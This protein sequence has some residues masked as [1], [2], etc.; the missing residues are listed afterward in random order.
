M[1]STSPSRIL[2]THTYAANKHYPREGEV[3]VVCLSQPLFGPGSTLGCGRDLPS[4]ATRHNYH[5]AVVLGLIVDVDQSIMEL[6][7]FPAPAYSAIDPISGLS[8]TRWLLSQP[9]DYQNT[10]IPLPYEQIPP[11]VQPNP[12]FPIPAQFGD[13]IEVG[14]WKD[15]KP[16]WIQVVPML[17]VLTFTTKVRIEFSWPGGRYYSSSTVQML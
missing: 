5:H 11:D 16:R 8:S 6:T 17:T 14:G 1:S 10:H 15:S 2:V 4:H 3:I 13:P 7:I 9:T 12:P